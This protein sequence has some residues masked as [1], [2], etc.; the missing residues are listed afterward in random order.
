MNIHVFTNNIKHDDDNDNTDN[1]KNYNQGN[2]TAGT[3]AEDFSLSIFQS[4]SPAGS[5]RKAN[6]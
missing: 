5:S 2:H 1:N 3:S 4:F 6:I